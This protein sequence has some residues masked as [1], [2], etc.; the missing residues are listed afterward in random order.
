MM[1][2]TQAICM[3]I[4]FLAIA[5]MFNLCFTGKSYIK[6]FY[7]TKNKDIV[8]TLVDDSF[9]VFIHNY[10]YA[11]HNKKT[12]LK[13]PYELNNRIT[14]LTDDEE[15]K[16]KKELEKK[17]KLFFNVSRIEFGNKS[18]GPFNSLIVYPLQIKKKEL[19]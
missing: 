14:M 13:I 9:N 10:A 17:F 1:T 6:E 12:I 5:A 18:K 8:E 3:A 7:E 16:Y 4:A 2:L 15:A 19:I 11:R